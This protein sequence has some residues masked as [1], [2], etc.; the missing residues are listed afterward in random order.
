MPN[1][2]NTMKF[3][4]I[5]NIVISKDNFSNCYVCTPIYSRTKDKTE[6]QTT[7]HGDKY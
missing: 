4:Q 2:T 3:V 6:Q 5:I 1:Y 7:V